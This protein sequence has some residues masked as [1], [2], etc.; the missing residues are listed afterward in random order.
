MQSHVGDFLQPSPVSSV[1]LPFLPQSPPCSHQHNTSVHTTLA[2]VESSVDVAAQLP[3]RPRGLPRPRQPLD[4]AAVPAAAAARP[5]VRPPLG[6]PGRHRMS[7]ADRARSARGSAGPHDA[8]RL[9]EAPLGPSPPP[10]RSAPGHAPPRRGLLQPSFGAGARGAGTPRRPSP[11]GGLVDTAPAVLSPPD[12]SRPKHPGSPQGTPDPLR[13]TPAST[14][15]GRPQDRAPAS[16]SCPPWY[17]PP[18]PLPLSPLVRP[19]PR[20]APRPPSRGRRGRCPARAGATPRRHFRLAAAGAGAGAGSGGAGPGRGR[21]GMALDVRRL[22]GLS[23][24]ELSAL[25]DDEEQLQ[26]MA[27]EMEEVRGARPAPRPGRGLPSGRPRPP[28]PHPA[29]PSGRRGAARGAW[30]LAVPPAPLPVLCRGCR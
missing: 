30:G 1:I 7:A 26:D 8:P 29:A 6:T 28:H 19:A 14:H 20:A 16:A 10:A 2:A 22:E 4:L 23:L 18:P 3:T 12:P 24:Q 17:R 27:R 15:G 11:A 9:W 13:A 21:A 5:S 25:L